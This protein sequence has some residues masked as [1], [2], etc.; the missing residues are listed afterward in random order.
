MTADEVGPARG[1]GVSSERV[2]HVRGSA[3]PA[4]HGAEDT[5]ARRVDEPPPEQSADPATGPE[6]HPDND[7]PSPPFDPD[8]SAGHS[9]G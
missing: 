8:T 4:T 6:I 2:G 7:L 3:V 5:S 1:M 9:D